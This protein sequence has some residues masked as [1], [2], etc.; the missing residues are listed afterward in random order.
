MHNH[1]LPTKHSCEI[2]IPNPI[3]FLQ[4]FF[5]PATLLLNSRQKSRRVFTGCLCFIFR[6]SLGWQLCIVENILKNFS[7]NYIIIMILK[8]KERKEL[9][10]VAQQNKFLWSMI[11]LFQYLLFCWF[12]FVFTGELN[13]IVIEWN[14]NILKY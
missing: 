7:I 11:S 1:S 13:K 9:H 6:W 8:R 12:F 2:F 14:N 10:I 4:E 3:T 5:F